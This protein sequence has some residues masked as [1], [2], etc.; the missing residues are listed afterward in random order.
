MILVHSQMLFPTYHPLTWLSRHVSSSGTEERHKRHIT[1]G[2]RSSLSPRNHLLFG[3]R[4]VGEWRQ[5]GDDTLERLACSCP[6]SDFTPLRLCLFV[7]SAPAV[8]SGSS[9]SSP[10]A[11]C[12]IHE[13]S[14]LLLSQSI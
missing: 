13:L 1:L 4:L 10:V 8:S 12:S 7:V 2:S 3:R 6:P 9:F 5:D 11:R 14:S